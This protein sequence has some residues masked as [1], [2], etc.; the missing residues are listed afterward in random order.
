ME[1]PRVKVRATRHFAQ[2]LLGACAYRQPPNLTLAFP[3]AIHPSATCLL[4]GGSDPA[5]ERNIVQRTARAAEA[6]AWELLEEL[7]RAHDGP[8]T[9]RHLGTRKGAK[10]SEERQ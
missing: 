6:K 1:G 4:F 7:L 9:G 5:D 10:R 2:S 3:L 8:A